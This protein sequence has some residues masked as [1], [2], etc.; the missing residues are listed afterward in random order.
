MSLVEPSANVER[1]PLPPLDFSLESVLKDRLGPPGELDEEG[2]KRREQLILDACDIGGTRYGF[3]LFDEDDDAI[4]ARYP[5]RSAST[6][7]L[8]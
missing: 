3:E 5:G 6:N 1:L 7:S 4:R 2:C 8:E